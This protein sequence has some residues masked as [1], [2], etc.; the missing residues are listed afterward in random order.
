MVN[1]N[2]LDVEAKSEGPLLLHMY[3]QLR[4]V[5]YQVETKASVVNLAGENHKIHQDYT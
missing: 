4:H 5:I 1:K 2:T 3:I